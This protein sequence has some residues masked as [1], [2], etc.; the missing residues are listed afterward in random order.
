MEKKNI[1]DENDDNFLCCFFYRFWAG[2]SRSRWAGLLSRIVYNLQPALKGW[3]GEGA[4]T[5]SSMPKLVSFL[6]KGKNST[7]ND[8]MIAYFFVIEW[9]GIYKE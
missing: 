3:S 2:S 5:G 8:V 4:P 6:L 9:V 1:D 7:V